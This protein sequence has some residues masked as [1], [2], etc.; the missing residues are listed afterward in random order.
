[1]LPDLLNGI[2][3]AGG[4]AMIW[5]NV[6]K[7]ARDKVFKGVSIGPTAFFDAWGFWNLYYYPSLHQWM[8]LLGGISIVIANTVWLGQM[9][10]YRDKTAR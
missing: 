1:M 6:R 4:S 3:E 5:L 10:Y 7:A 2:F 8:S 9:L